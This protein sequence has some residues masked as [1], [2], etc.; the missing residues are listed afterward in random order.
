M[1]AAILFA[2]IALLWIQKSGYFLPGWV[3]WEKAQIECTG[4]GEPDAI[5]LRARRIYVLK[6]G[7]TVWQSDRKTPV[8]SVL[9]ADIDRDGQAELMLLCWKRGRY[10]KSRPFW[11]E[12]DEKTWSQHIYIYDWDEGSVKPIWMASD[13]GLEAVRWSFDEQSRLTVR[14]RSGAHTVWDW[15]SWGL[16]C[17]DSKRPEKGFG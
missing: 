16:T 10:G 9:W 2:A 3:E 14:D 17:V 12:E 4:S 7:N 8:Q 6:G 15:I 1:I 11:V 13:I 5:C